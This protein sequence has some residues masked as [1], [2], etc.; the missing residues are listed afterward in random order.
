MKAKRDVFIEFLIKFDVKL[1]KLL[2]AGSCF[3]KVYNNSA[4]DVDTLLS[5]DYSNALRHIN[6]TTSTPPKLCKKRYLRILNK[7]LVI[8]S[9]SE[10]DEEVDLKK[11]GYLKISPSS[12]IHLP[13]L[14]V[15]YIFFFI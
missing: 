3:H 1:S 15:K 12:V 8:R 7:S 5:R 14:S 11:N 13:H 6:C 4:N 10:I 9:D 2:T